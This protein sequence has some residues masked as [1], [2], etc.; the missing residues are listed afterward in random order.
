[1]ASTGSSYVSKSKKDFKPKA[2]VRRAG[3][4]GST[5][6][7]IRGSVDRQLQSN[8]ST[9]Q[10]PAGRSSAALPSSVI[11]SGQ[12]NHDAAS[13][14]SLVPHLDRATPI[15]LPSHGEI[16]RST[17][18]PNVPSTPPS[19]HPPAQDAVH[20]L[21]PYTNNS[22]PLQRNLQPVPPPTS[23]SQATVPSI[24]NEEHAATPR[25][26]KRRKVNPP[27]STKPVAPATNTSATDV[28]TSIEVEQEEEPRPAVTSTT[29]RASTTAA[30]IEATKS[31]IRK[32]RA[33]EAAA[34]VVA[35]AVRGA[36]PKKKAAKRISTKSKGKQRVGTVNE[37]VTA[38]AAEDPGGPEEGNRKKR[39]RKRAKT[40]DNA[41]TIEIA[42]ALV[43]MSDLCKDVRT[44]RKSTREQELQDLDWTAVVKKQR[45][46]EQRVSN[47]ETPPPETV[48]QMLD[49]VGREQGQEEMPQAY[50][51]IQIVNGQLMID[52]SSLRVD[53]HANA[54]RVRNAEP[55]EVIDENQLTRKVNAGSWMKREKKES[56]DEVMVDRFYDGL[57]MFGTDFEMI[58]KM[59]PGRSRR[60]IK[61]KFVKEER[62]NP[63]RI[64]ETLMGE[65]KA[66]DMEEL[67]KLSNITFMDPKELERDMEDDRK[68]LEEE[69]ATEKEA[70]DEAARQRADEA[71]AES[72]AV[73]G[74]GGRD[75]STKENEGQGAHGTEAEAGTISIKKPAKRGRKPKTA[76]T[77]KSAPPAVLASIEGTALENAAQ[78]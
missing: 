41:E 29:T 58:S 43:K 30:R 62:Q 4:Q 1:M 35:D 6:T 49:R 15:P 63:E 70:L 21:Q 45:E 36:R 31:R 17:P 60:H 52:E 32:Q 42:P 51:D 39:G 38:P 73:T 18:Q 72:A 37:D 69:Q 12:A 34:A 16:S 77:K 5:R 14:D 3:A 28:T 27:Q 22:L 20:Q 65:K 48:D 11:A 23:L 57:R 24:S 25:A 71:A 2:P 78:A 40:P 54:A 64:H 33:E 50:P 59:F 76:V 61:L 13:E 74:N 46:K 55:K 66:V 75:S 68:R 7:S 47:N 10:P 26:S 44:G 56:W 53:R 8:P 19:A 67:S 9:P